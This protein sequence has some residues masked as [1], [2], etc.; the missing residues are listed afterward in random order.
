MQSRKVCVRCGVEKAIRAFDND[1]SRDDGVYP[2][3]KLCRKKYSPTSQQDIDAPLNG[4]ACPLCDTQIRGHANRRF[5]SNYCRDRVGALRKRYNLSVEQ[6]RA[7]LERTGGRCPIC[8]KRPKKW[9]VEHDHNTNLVTGLVCTGCNIGLLAY[10]N[11][12]VGVAERLL[13]YLQ[14]PP[15]NATIGA[16]HVP[17]DPSGSRRGKSKIHTRWGR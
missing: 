15:A 10:S 2:W 7:M 11:H 14:N 4:H 1:K 8:E 6:Y 9:V 12:D 16:V 17:D 5:C 3:C 13:K